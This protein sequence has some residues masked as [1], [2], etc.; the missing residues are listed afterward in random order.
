MIRIILQGCCGKMGRMVTQCSALFPELEIVAGV[1]RVQS[2]PPM[3]YPVYSQADEVQK[4]VW[5]T[6]RPARSPFSRRPIFRSA[7]RPCNVF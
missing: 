5:S 2:D 4:T 7:L 3:P 1:D 6:A